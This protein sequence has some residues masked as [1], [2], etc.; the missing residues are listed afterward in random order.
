MF[1][2]DLLFNLQ[3]MF[4]LVKT[5]KYVGS[6]S[7]GVTYWPAHY[8]YLLFVR[9]VMYSVEPVF[10]QLTPWQV[11]PHTC[12]GI[13]SLW[14]RSSWHLLGDVFGGI[15]CFCLQSIDRCT[16]VLPPIPLSSC[17][18]L[19]NDPLYLSFLTPSVIT[20]LGDNAY[21]RWPRSVWYNRFFLIHLRGG[22]AV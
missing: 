22:A 18:C 9:E 17:D 5:V 7:G 6:S 2:A 12:H 1:S 14:Y 15:Y 8:T 16:D 4:V 13:R 11:Q 3:W 21:F 10:A 20:V 19:L